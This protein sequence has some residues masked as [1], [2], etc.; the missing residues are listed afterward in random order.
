MLKDR[1][2][3]HHEQS[4]LH[5]RRRR[6]GRQIGSRIAKMRH[7]A[8]LITSQ[9]YDFVGIICVQ[10]EKNRIINVQADAFKNK[11]LTKQTIK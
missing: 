4:P 8:K 2:K 1:N 9:T 5:R 7:I 10:Y 3:I 6:I 11:I